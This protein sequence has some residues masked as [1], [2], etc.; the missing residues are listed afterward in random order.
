MC[1]KMLTNYNTIYQNINELLN[2]LNQ[3]GVDP[4]QK[5]HFENDYLIAT[6][7]IENYNNGKTEKL[8]TAG[9][10]AIG[11]LHELYKWIW[12]IK[13]CPEFEKLLPHFGMLSESASRINEKTK[14][15]SPVTGKQDDKTNKLIETI[16]AMFAIKVG[17]NIDLDDPIA[18]SNGENPDIIFDYSGQRIS[19]ACKTLR[20]S[21]SNTILD[22][23]RSAAKQIN[24]AE[25][26]KGYIAINAMN[27]L[28]HD[29]IVN[30]V[31]S[32]LK[33]PF[34]LLISDIV[35]LYES[36]Q[37]DATKEL[38]EIFKDHKVR[39]VILTFVHSTTRLAS[40]AG[41]L[42][43]M[44]KSTFA[45]PLRKNDENEVDLNLLNKVNDFIH[46]RL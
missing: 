5:S 26:D 38:D 13:D 24:R 12:S 20:G 30:N 35:G 36:M 34:F 25:C 41:N 21:S 44:I 46:Q 33:E 32:N 15:I 27:I 19:V 29:K 39:P 17:S 18:S 1:E 8:T 31:Y 4:A 40:N 42:S 6:D 9:R 16:V 43:T 14:M 3:I 28:P 45:S 22:N 23:L 37:I 10:N 11:G 2:F 7:Y